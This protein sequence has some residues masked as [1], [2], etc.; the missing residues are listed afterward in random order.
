MK[1]NIFLTLTSVLFS[2]LIAEFV[3]RLLPY[4]GIRH[5]PN[6]KSKIQVKPNFLLI[7]DKTLGWKL[8]L[9]GVYQISY[10][11]ITLNK[12]TV[13]SLGNRWTG[14]TSKSNLPLVDILGCSFTFGTSVDDSSSYPFQ[15]QKMMPFCQIH[16]K[17]VGG[18][19]LLQMFLSLKKDVELGNV[20][21]IAVF[22]YA[23][24][25]NERTPL[26]KRWIRN[27]NF[28]NNLDNKSKFRVAKFNYPYAILDKNKALTIKYIQKENWPSDFWFRD[29]SYL[30]DIFNTIYD[31]LYD[32]TQ[33]KYLEEI[34]FWLVLEIK[35]YCSEHNIKLVF[36]GMTKKSE[37]FLSKISTQGID[38]IFFDVDLSIPNMNLKP[39][40]PDHPSPAAHKLYAQKLFNYLHFQKGYL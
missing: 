26:S 27:L 35:R 13:D 32:K 30:V 1:K 17:G 28:Y 23:H 25:H 29:K 7:E 12:V 8:G 24:F 37:D 36:T 19:S 14:N 2:V 22:N 5:T 15:L 39:F 4:R 9:K 10:D 6:L 33:E 21:K 18:Y 11:S 34:S 38:T 3:L 20:P 31:K 16:N 40:D